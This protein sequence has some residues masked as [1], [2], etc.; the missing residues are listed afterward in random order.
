MI[1]PWI[2]YVMDTYRGIIA[3]PPLKER[4]IITTYVDYVAFSHRLR[5][6]RF[7][8]DNREGA[9]LCRWIHG[10]LILD[11]M[12]LN[13]EVLGFTNRWYR[14]ALEA[15]QSVILPNEISIQV[16]T[17]P[18]FLGTK[19]EAFRNRGMHDFYESRDL[20]DFLAVLDG[21][22]SLLREIDLTPTELRVY[23]AEAAAELLAESRFMD[24]LPGYLMPDEG[25][26]QRLP[27]LLRKLQV[28]SRQ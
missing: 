22:D 7:R 27:A 4:F 13:Q 11:V 18:Y 25:S 23:L 17:A 28:I 26:Q 21:R 1:M 2:S 10:D 15:S 20:E 16:I 6:L 3:A 24:A 12:P 14:D 5:S 8:E 9:P 19:M